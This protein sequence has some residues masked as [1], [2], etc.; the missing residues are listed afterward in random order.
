M[1]VSSEIFSEVRRH[2]LKLV[3]VP[4]RVIYTPY[5]RGK[6]QSTLNAFGVFFKLLL[7]LAR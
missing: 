1:E 3:E 5:S 6:G 7:R 2:Y 4:I